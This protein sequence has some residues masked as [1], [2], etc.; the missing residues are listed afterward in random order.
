[1]V[2][3]AG[4][5]VL[6]N[7]QAEK[8]VRLRARRAARAAD[9]DIATATPSRWPRRSPQAVTSDAAHSSDGRRPRAVRAAQGRQRVP[10]EIS[11]SPLQTD[12]GA[13]VMSAVRDISVRKKA[14]QKFRGLLESAPDAMVIVNRDG[15]IVLVNTQTERLF[16]SSARR[17]AG[18]ERR[19][20]GAR[21][22][23]RPASGP[24][25]AFS[26][27]R[28]AARW[29]RDRSSR[30]AR[31]RHGVSRRDQPEPAR[32]RKT[33]RSCRARF[34]ISP[35]GGASSARYTRKTSSCENA[36]AAKDRFL[37]TM[38]HELRTPMNAIIGF[39][40]TL[41]MKLRRASHRRAGEAAR[42]RSREAPAPL[43]SDQRPARLARIE[44]GKVRAAVE[45]VDCKPLEDVVATLRPFADQKAVF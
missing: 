14:E 1:M 13:L 23:P 12:A 15:K 16:G 18:Q 36:A 33:A 40:G 34:A 22:L 4:R 28:V 45:D 29:A 26:A 11:L 6:T 38:S 39:T 9:R 44:S 8:P 24:R 2:N 21:A 41:L 5:I 17:A 10:V 43:S 31:R 30:A 7:G 19:G 25:T 27:P 20:A 3:A 42:D 35:S 32:R 37:A